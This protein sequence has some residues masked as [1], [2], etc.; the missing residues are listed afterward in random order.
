M[1]ARAFRGGRRPSMREV[2]CATVHCARAVCL[3]ATRCRFSRTRGRCRVPLKLAVCALFFLSEVLLTFHFFCR[4]TGAFDGNREDL[5]DFLHQSFFATDSF[6]RMA[7]TQLEQCASHGKLLQEKKKLEKLHLRDLLKD[8]ARNDLLIRSTDQGVYLDFSRQ[9]ITLETLQHLVN[10]ADERQVPAMVKRMFSG[11]KINQTENRAV[12]HVALRMPEGSEPVHVDGKNVLDEVHAVLR[13]IRV[14]S[15]KV[16]SGEI[17]G[18]TGKKLVNVISIGIGGS[19]LGTEFVHLALAAEGYAAEKAHGRQIHFLAN[20]DPVDVW[21]AE[22]GFDP[23]ETLVVVISKT[24]TTAETMMN[25]RSVRDWYLHHYK[26]DERALGAHFCAVSTNLDGTSKFGIQSDRVF[27]FWDWVGGRYSVTSAVGI[28]PLALQ[29]GYDVAQE[30]LNGAHAMDVHFKTAELADNLP[31][32]MGLISVWNAT[33]FG[34][35]NVAVLPYAQALLRF[36]A[37]IQQL[38]MES[39]GKRVTMDGKTLDFDVG[40]IFF[41]EPGTNGQHSFYQ[42]IHQGR[43]IPAEFIG[44]CKSQRAIKLK[45]EPVSNHD[46]LMSNF[47]AQPDALAFGKTPE[48]LRKEGIPE[49]LVPHKTFPG[50][51]PSCML[52]FPEISPFHIGQLLALYEHRVAVEGWLWGINSFDQWGVELGKV[53]AKG[54][55]GILQKRRE[56]KAPHESGQSELCSSTRKILEH[57]VQQSKA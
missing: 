54:V 28:L 7:P 14:F 16:R 19:Y 5:D 50:D 39:N 53:L 29:Y 33:F 11:E 45:E 32:L 37:H 4:A 57:Y 35:S 3:A 40:E 30:F 17:R 47:F 24:F 6:R 48:E 18:H 9:K 23:E 46:E 44:F 10:L 51:R 22:R 25:A 41:G 13:R 56:G 31:M 8:E 43:V 21:L 12:L 34:Y 20:V 36:P 15:E 38:T 26:G 55:R 1:G 49:K 42:L 2:S 27:G 52:L